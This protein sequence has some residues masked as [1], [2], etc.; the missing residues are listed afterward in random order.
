MHQLT[1]FF[2]HHWMLASGFLIA[3]I[4]IFVEEVRSGASGGKRM[5]PQQLTYC[6]NQGSAKVVDIR[7]VAAFR[8]GHVTGAVNIPE[9][10][11]DQKI[12][13][14]GGKERT[15]IIIAGAQLQKAHIVARKLHKA[16]YTDVHQLSG[17]INAWKNASL[18]LIKGK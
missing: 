14:L 18:P 6:I 13:Q 16:G 17:G 3:L 9:S 10:D 11:F 7:D 5:S 8:E 1:Q 15:I 4:F 12:G 2:L